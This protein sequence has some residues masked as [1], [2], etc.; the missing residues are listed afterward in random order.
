MPYDEVPTGGPEPRPGSTWNFQFPTNPYLGALMGRWNEIL[1]IQTERMRAQ[2]Q[3]DE[4]AFQE[5]L[6]KREFERNMQTAD[7]ERMKANDQE[8]A[9]T[10]QFNRAQIEQARRDAEANCQA[11]RQR[12]I[13]CAAPGAGSAYGG[14]STGGVPDAKIDA[15][16][17]VNQVATPAYGPR[18]SGGGTNVNVVAQGGGG[19]YVTP[20]GSGYFSA[21]GAAN[22]A[23]GFSLPDYWNTDAG[24]SDD[25]RRDRR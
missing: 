8:T 22:P 2:P 10:S 16:P 11:A 5:W 25:E 13:P 14:S 1:G 18:T 4:V 24:A 12:G 17:R 15:S 6:R 9:N 3:R 21:A 23:A 19:G 20:G 7:F